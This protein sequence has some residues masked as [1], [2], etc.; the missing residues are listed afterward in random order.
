MA[1]DTE[2][3]LIYNSLLSR[4]G[5]QGWWP[6][7]SPFEV[8]IGAILTQSVSWVNVEK[9][10]KNMK[11][12]GLLE[13]EKLYNKKISEI[14]PLIR[15]TR[16]YNEKAQKIKNF[17]NFLFDEYDGC[18]QKM[19]DEDTEI[20][21]Q[22]LL[23]IKGLGEETVDSILLYAFNKPVFVIDAYTKRIFSRYGLIKEGARYKEIQMFFLD[24]LPQDT[25]LYNDFHAQIVNLGK[26]ICK[27]SPDCTICQIKI[28]N[29]RARCRFCIKN[30]EQ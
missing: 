25:A 19:S 24:N 9:A 26:N 10:I 6:G 15:S 1:S 20:L 23:G 3:L 2:L 11:E 8:I 27:S 30:V 18:L 5:H 21:R 12:E 13:P 17:M 29:T 7:D 14:A 28:I 22:K 16:F 4:F